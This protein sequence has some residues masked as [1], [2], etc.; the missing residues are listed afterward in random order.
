VR[1]LAIVLTVMASVGYDPNDNTT[2]MIPSSSVGI[3][4]S[5]GIFGGSLRGLRFGLVQGLF[6]RTA[7]SETTP[8]NNIMDDMV[9]VLQSAGATIVTINETVYNAT[10]IATMDVQAWEYREDMDAYLQM[11]SVGGSHPST[12]N[13]LYGSGKFVVIPSQYNY[14]K[15]ALVSST[16]NIS[17]APTKLGIQNLTTVLRTT[18]SDNNLDALIYPEQKNLVVKIGSPSQS[19][20]N[21]ILA[22]L[23]GFP[24]VTVPAGFSPVTEDAP[25]GVPIGMEILGLPWTESKLLNIASHISDLTCVRRMP[26]FENQSVEVTTAY[27]FVPTITPNTAN[28]PGAYPIGVL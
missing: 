24:V 3:D 19:G 10:A 21:G 9:S 5:A 15:T 27:D 26:A 11:P 17:Y 25:I 28:I 18:F 13:E 7:S 2:A 22:A 20:R 6:N 23:T 16:S 14:V 4:Y 1:D 8:V 12:L